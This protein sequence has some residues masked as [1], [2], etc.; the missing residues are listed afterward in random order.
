MGE[1]TGLLDYKR[2]NDLEIAPK[3]RIQN[4]NGI[5]IPLLWKSSAYGGGWRC[6]VL[7]GG[8]DP[9]MASGC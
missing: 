7:P 1:P 5:H 4:F 8:H 2:E 9:G 3:E 6:T